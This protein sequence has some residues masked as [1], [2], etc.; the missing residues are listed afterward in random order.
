MITTRA[1]DGAKNGV[2]HSVI[3]CVWGGTIIF[4]VGWDQFYLIAQLDDRCIVLW[5]SV[6]DPLYH[7]HMGPIKTSQ[8]PQLTRGS[9][10]P[11]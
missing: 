1:P 10:K 3:F 8:V 6:F 11:D 7:G 4:S 5:V 9:G 2:K